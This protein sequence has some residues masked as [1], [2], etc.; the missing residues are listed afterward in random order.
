MHPMT[1][2]YTKLSNLSNDRSIYINL[3]D[4]VRF[5][6]GKYEYICLERIVHVL[7]D[8]TLNIHNIYVV[9]NQ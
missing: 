7:V 9:K 3:F 4:H 8:I 6:A 2:L 5:F 1:L